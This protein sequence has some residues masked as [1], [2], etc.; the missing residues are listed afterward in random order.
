MG[1]FSAKGRRIAGS[2][3]SSGGNQRGAPGRSAG[4]LPGEP[5]NRLVPRQASGGACGKMGRTASRAEELREPGTWCSPSIRSPRGPVP[6]LH[7]SIP[8]P[9][10]GN[11]EEGESKFPS[12]G[13]FPRSQLE[14]EL[15]WDKKLG[16]SDSQGVKPRTYFFLPNST[17]HPSSDVWIPPQKKRWLGFVTGPY[18]KTTKKFLLKQCLARMNLDR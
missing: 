10:Q 1:G 15:D 16:C 12:R 13:H 18:L 2:L 8:P 9:E 5:G 11:W 6:V 17:L 14:L 7:P 3:A 4:T